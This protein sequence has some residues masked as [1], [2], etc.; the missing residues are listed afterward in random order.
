M[1]SYVK[2]VVKIWMILEYFSYTMLSKA[3]H[4]RWTFIVLWS[5][6]LGD[7]HSNWVLI[8]K[9]DNITYFLSFFWKCFNLFDNFYELSIIIKKT[10]PCSSARQT[11]TFSSTFSKAHRQTKTLMCIGARQSFFPW[12]YPHKSQIQLPSENFSSP[13]KFF[14]SRNTICDTSC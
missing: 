11:K 7:W 6:W 10:L 14:Y 8:S 3:K 12:I 9:P 4:L 1:I 2:A 13:W 5:M